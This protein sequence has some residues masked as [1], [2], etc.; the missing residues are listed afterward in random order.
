MHFLFASEIK[1]LLRAPR[2]RGELDPRAL[3]E[4][5]TFW[6]TLAPRTA[7][8][9]M[10]ELP[11]G[12]SLM[13]REHGDVE[14]EPYWR[15][16]LSASR[17]RARSAKRDYAEELRDAARR[18]DAPALARRRAGRRVSERRAR[19]VVI[20]AHRAGASPTRRCARSRS[21]SRR[22]VRRER[23]TSARAVERLRHR[24]P[25]RAAARTQDIADVL[26]RR[27]SGTPSGRCCAPRRR[28][29][30]C[31]RG[32]C[33]SHG[34]KVVLTG[35]GADEV[36]GGYDIFKEAKIRRFWARRPSRRCGRCCCG[37]S[38]RTCRRCRRSRTAYL[39]AF[40]RARPER[41]RRPVL[42]APAALGADAQ[43]A[44][45]STRRRCATRSRLRP[46]RAICARAAGRVRQLAP[47]L[48]GAV[49]RDALPAAR[50][51]PVVAGRPRGDGARRRGPLPVPRSPRGGV[52]RAAAAAAEDEGAATRSTC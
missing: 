10:L 36:F 38:I 5:F 37:G 48:P 13:L 43:A 45:C 49:P 47:V 40:F 29:C 18:R 11:P 52:R 24:A 32:S 25:A 21:R 51:H 27:R 1:A 4:V 46:D 8:K 23:A 26:P 7:F 31:C 6:S 22:R 14:V 20:T 44:S 16:R 15:A 34:Y 3:D 19:L 33:A 12:H 9:G 35:E 50:L 41:P 39:R 28:R 2:R 42:L 30:S 17:T